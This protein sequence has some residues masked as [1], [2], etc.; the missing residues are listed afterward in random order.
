MLFFCAQLTAFVSYIYDGEFK[1]EF[2]C[3]INLPSR[4]RGKNIYQTIDTFSK[5]NEIKWEPLRGF[6]TEVASAI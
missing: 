1:D 2:L 3:I 6:C 4:T 5:A